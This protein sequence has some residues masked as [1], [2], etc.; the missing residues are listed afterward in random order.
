MGWKDWSYVKKGAI[1][2]I[3][4][5]IIL[6][7]IG[8]LVSFKCPVG[9]ADS[10]SS[11]GICK[12]YITLLAVPFIGITLS[13]LLIQ[14]YLFNIEGLNLAMSLS[15]FIF[16]LISFLIGTFIGW[17]VGKIKTRGQSVE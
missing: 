2:G 9:F 3:V 8:L 1:I 7:L 5:G 14:Y 15:P 6:T 10:V 12:S 11:E 13:I 4:L 16:T 17:F